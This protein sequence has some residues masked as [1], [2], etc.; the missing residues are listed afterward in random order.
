[1]SQQPGQAFSGET[2]GGRGLGGLDFGRSF[3]E[4]IAATMTLCSRRVAARKLRKIA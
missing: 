2:K 4:S 1:M 3:V